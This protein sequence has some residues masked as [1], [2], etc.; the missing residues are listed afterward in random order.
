MKIEP[1]DT[2]VFDPPLRAIYVNDPSFAEAA[3]DPVAPTKTEPI[4]LETI[5][6]ELLS[7]DVP[8]ESWIP[9]IARRVMRTGT[10]TR[11]IDGVT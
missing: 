11:P 2:A 6:G 3:L 1:S 9:I 10:T 4:S 5:S 7:L 8:V